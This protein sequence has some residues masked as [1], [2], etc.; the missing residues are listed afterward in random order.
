MAQDEVF[1]GSGTNPYLLEGGS[2]Q[3]LL[4]QLAGGGT[5]GEKRA[6]AAIAGAQALSPA[7]E[8]VDPAQLAIRFFSQMGANASKPGST[9]LSAAAE[10]LPTAADYLAQV[11]KRNRELE[12]ARGPLAVQLATA[13]KP[14]TAGTTTSGSYKLNKDIDGVGKKGEVVTLSTADALLYAKADP[15]ALLK[16]DKPSSGTETERFTSYLTEVGPKIVNGTATPVEIAT[17]STYYQK[18]TKGYESSRTT[19]DGK[20]ETI[21]IAGIDLTDTAL[22]IPEGFDAEKILDEKARDFGPQAV[23]A[24]F[25]ER[26][27]YTEGL[28][29]E[30]LSEGYQNNFKDLTADNFSGWF[31]TT[32]QTAQGQRFYQASRNFIAAVLRKESGA[33]ISD[34]EYI[35]GLK[36]YFPQIGDTQEVIDRKDALRDSAITG[37][38]NDSG[39]AFSAI[40]PN[41]VS[42]LSFTVGDKKEDIINPRGYSTYKLEKTSKGRDLY[43]G[44]TLTALTIEELSSLL[45]KANASTYT[46]PQLRMINEELNKKKKEAEALK[47]E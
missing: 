12:R 13:L 2:L 46:A 6:L 10:A 34:G 1:G 8:K 17:Y 16:F 21:R 40:Y 24:G 7:T 28:V 15:S 23:T 9:A 18:L 39:D 22:P 37:M 47:N 44:S 25:A 5:E 45:R 30:V 19:P 33:A 35:N 41:A 11:N 43:F 20:T 36:Q 26:M 3:S 31:G 42:Y 29:R 14:P 4:T 32:F 38:I 27:L